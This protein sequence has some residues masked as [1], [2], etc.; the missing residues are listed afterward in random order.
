[1][2]ACGLTRPISQALRRP[3]MRR[4]MLP[5]SA[6]YRFI[7]NKDAEATLQLTDGSAAYKGQVFWLKPLDLN[8][9]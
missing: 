1:M 5:F 3:V 6:E 9:A 8:T 2:Q 4:V 7:S